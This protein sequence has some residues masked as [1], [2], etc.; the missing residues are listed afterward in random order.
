M[1]DYE[2][3]VHFL[4]ME[5]RNDDFDNKSDLKFKPKYKISEDVSMKEI[6]KDSITNTIMYDALYIIEFSPFGLFECFE[7]IFKMKFP[8]QYLSLKVMCGIIKTNMNFEDENLKFPYSNG[9]EVL[10]P[11]AYIQ[12]A[13]KH[14]NNIIEFL[15]IFCELF[16]VLFVFNYE[17]FHIYDWSKLVHYYFESIT[18]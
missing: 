13:K 17:N 12:F 5:F 11:D 3:V 2:E 9:K 15:T 6:L 7:Y 16:P 10:E 1:E 18:K 4:W 14:R 8:Q